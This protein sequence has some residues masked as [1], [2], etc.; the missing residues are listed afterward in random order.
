LL[1]LSGAAL[2]VDG[3]VLINQSTALTGLGGCDTPGFP[4]TIC[5]PGSYKHS[6]NLTVASETIDGIRVTADNVTVDL[7]GF[8]VKG[9]RVCTG[10]GVAIT[11]TGGSFGLSYGVAA[12]FTHNL[13]IRNGSVTGFGFGIY[14][15]DSLLGDDSANGLVEE[16][17]V[18]SNSANGMGVFDS[19]VRRC[20]MSHNG[21]H[22]IQAYGSVV[23]S[24]VMVGNYFSGLSLGAGTTATNNVS[25]ANRFGVEGGGS[26]IG[27]NTFLDNTEGSLIPNN[28]LLS[29]EN[30]ACGKWIGGTPY[31][32]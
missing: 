31:K 16:V 3:T 26:I 20:S 27:S 18:Y 5:Q 30:N 13:T 32:C 29:Q 28:T 2:A 22:G 6:G 24:N 25:R 12:F 14:I 7:N 23:E 8:T 9:A 10:T 21:F 1:F 11:C 17:H 15:E 19:V 4:I